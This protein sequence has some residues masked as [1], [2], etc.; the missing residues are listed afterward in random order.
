MATSTR[1]TL[2]DAM[3]E[4]CRH[5]DIV[6]LDHADHIMEDI[7]K[8]IE[9]GA[10]KTECEG[11]TVRICPSGW[12]VTYYHP[13]S[14]DVLAAFIEAMAAEEREAIVTREYTDPAGKTM[15]LRI[16][17]KPVADPWVSNGGYDQ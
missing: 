7:R 13:L 9:G 10:M 11:H 12:T 4:R 17:A 6:G 14:E 8:T 2:R 1:W 16:T 15:V 5:P 3:A